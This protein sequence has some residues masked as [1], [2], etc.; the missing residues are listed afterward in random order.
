MKEP[1]DKRTKE[2]KEWKETQGVEYTQTFPVKISKDKQPLNLPDEFIDLL[3]NSTDPDYYN[4]KT[5]GKSPKDDTD[6]AIEFINE[7]TNPIGEGIKGLGDKIEK[8]T[9]ATGIKKV[10]KSIF[11]D[12]CGCDKRKDILNKAFPSKR[13]ALRCL[14]E[15]QYEQYKLYKETRTLNVW[16]EAE[17]HFTIKLYAHVFAI[18]Y[19]PNDLCRNCTGSGKI[20]F[21]ISK[22]LDAVYK[23][24]K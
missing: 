3:N 10:V 4:K 16:N 13:K 5:S 1:K 9:E 20:L 17:I 7:N 23:S 15:Q 14:D 19:N 8:I 21:R 24:Y 12:D 18:Q 6:K 22:E 11:G 2:Y